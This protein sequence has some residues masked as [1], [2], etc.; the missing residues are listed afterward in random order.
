MSLR[1]LDLQDIKDFKP[2]E[3][4]KVVIDFWADWCM[5]CSVQSREIES[6]SKNNKDVQVFKVDIEIEEFVDLIERYKISTIPTLLFFND[7]E[8]K[9]KVTG[10][11]KETAIKEIIDQI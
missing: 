3:K 2:I 1:A 5:P 10:L 7:G 9:K 6:F 4:G 11:T 8:L